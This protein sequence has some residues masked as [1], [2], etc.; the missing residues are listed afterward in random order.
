MDLLFRT[1]FGKGATAAAVAAPSRQPDSAA[2]T[3][4]P[5]TVS[6]VVLDVASQSATIEWWTTNNLGCQLAAPTI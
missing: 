3:S 1:H 5:S 2:D 4:L 6:R